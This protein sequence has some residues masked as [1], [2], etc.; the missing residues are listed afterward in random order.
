MNI[1]RTLLLCLTLVCCGCPLAGT[2]AS[3]TWTNRSGGSW[4]N[5]ANWNAAT[6]ASGPGNTANF[7]TVNLP[8]D[9]TVTLDASRT[10]GNLNFDDQN[11]T[12]HNWSI[13]AGSGGTLTLAGTTPTITVLSAT[14]TITLPVGGTAGLTKSGQ[15]TLR[16]GGANAITYGGT[17][18]VNAGTLGLGTATFAST[19]ALNLSASSAVVESS[20]TLN[21]VVNTSATAIDVY[22]SGTLRLVATTNSSTW[23]DLYFGPNHSANSCWG[24]RL[25]AG[26]DLGGTQR[27]V[28]GQTGHNGVGMYGLT[29]A[30]CQFSGSVAGSGGLTFIAQNSWTGSEPME[31]PFALNANNSFTGPVTIQRGSVYL[32]NANALACSNVL[33]FAPDSGNNARL[34]LYGNNACVSDLSS[35]GAGSALVANGN[36]KTGASLTLGAVT[37]TVIQNN[38]GTFAGALTDTYREYPG[39]G[40]GTTGPLNLLKT[41]P[42]LLRLTGISTYSGTTTVSAGTLQVDGWLNTGGVTVQNG[43]TLAGVGELDGSVTV[44]AGGRLAPGGSSAIGLMTINNAL[45]L[46]GTAMMKLSKSGVALSNDRV[47]GMTALDYS[48]SLLATNIGAGSLAAGDSFILFTANDYSG[49]SRT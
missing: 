40:S 35:A 45:N 27:Y 28:F 8:A 24:A 10:I 22:G 9:I 31:V 4:T 5:A 6:I 48:G 26:V 46:A 17:T 19:N 37:L 36:L 7:T 32:G 15:G 1:R 14:T 34:F 41:G 42:A 3:G 18:T 49:A 20:G 47:T 29:N 2:A 13:N 43:A 44:Q 21:L 39:S 16:L 11:T 33:T 38:D 30:D 23:P 25:A 12:K